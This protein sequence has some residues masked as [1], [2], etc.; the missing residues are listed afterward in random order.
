MMEKSFSSKRQ[1][2]NQHG[3]EFSMSDIPLQIDKYTK[4]INREENKGTIQ[5]QNHCI[6]LANRHKCTK[7]RLLIRETTCNDDPT[8]TKFINKPYVL[9]PISGCVRKFIYRGAFCT[10]LLKVHNK[11]HTE[12]NEIVI[13]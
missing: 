1:Y 7:K 9:C 6:E 3:I 10:H 5:Q 8:K 4:I 13:Q 11:N 12:A 2:N